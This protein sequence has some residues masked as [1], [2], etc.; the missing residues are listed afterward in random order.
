[1]EGNQCHNYMCYYKH[2]LLDFKKSMSYMLFTEL[3]MSFRFY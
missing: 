2:A 1:M 3:K